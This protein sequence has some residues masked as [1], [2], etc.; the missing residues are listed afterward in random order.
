MADQL[1]AFTG[2]PEIQQFA[3]IPP[4]SNNIYP[5]A[6]VTFS[7]EIAIPLKGAGD[8]ARTRVICDLPQNYAY[9]M[10]Q[11][12]LAVYD[13][14]GATDVDNYGNLGTVLMQWT[15]PGNETDVL[16]TLKS[17]GIQP[18]EANAG[19]LKTYCPE[20]PF[21]E[22]FYNPAKPGASKFIRTVWYVFDTDAVNAT[23]AL[24]GRYYFSF[25]QY[26]INQVSEVAVNAPQPVSIR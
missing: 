12:F 19:G 11:T 3:G 23:I 4:T 26:D 8:T 24:D 14:A 18:Y 9:T 5:R 20:K 13:N 6:R 7:A 17:N 21:G 15:D 22:V 16:L 1:N 2:V 25:L 10:D